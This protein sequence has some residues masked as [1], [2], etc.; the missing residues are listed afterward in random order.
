MCVQKINEEA[1]KFANSARL[2]REAEN[3]EDHEKSLRNLQEAL[4]ELNAQDNHGR[5]KRSMHTEV[6]LRLNPGAFIRK[7]TN[8]YYGC[9]STYF[10]YPGS[11]T[12]P[13]TALD[14]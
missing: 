12:T 8:D 3:D 6:K 1:A 14:R 5:S 2:K 9:L 7:A 4:Q 10:T 11:L 13:G